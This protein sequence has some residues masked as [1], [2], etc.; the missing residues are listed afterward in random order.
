ML[1]SLIIQTQPVEWFLSHENG[2]G[3]C[4][5]L[6]AL[7]TAWFVMLHMIREI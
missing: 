1:Q 7:S 4:G 6:R 5:T 2:L 3:G